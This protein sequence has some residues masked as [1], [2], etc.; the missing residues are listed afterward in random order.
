M[1]SGVILSWSEFQMWKF[2]WNCEILGKSGFWWMSLIDMNRYCTWYEQLLHLIYELILNRQYALSGVEFGQG[3]KRQWW[4]VSEPWN[5]IVTLWLLVMNCRNLNCSVYPYI[6]CCI[7]LNCRSWIVM[8]N[9][10]WLLHYVELW[11]EIS[12]LN[13][14]RM[15]KLKLFVWVWWHMN[16]VWIHSVM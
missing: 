8:P 9:C 13:C 16:W 15:W 7:K 3:L 14:Y 6:T 2:L 1:A 12:K 10:D 5:Q 4:C 11:Y